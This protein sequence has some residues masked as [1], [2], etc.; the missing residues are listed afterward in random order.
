[1]SYA[2][3]STIYLNWKPP[4]SLDLSAVDRD[5][6]YCVDVY[7]ADATSFHIL[8]N[9]SVFDPHYNFSL[10]NPDPNEVFTFVVMPRSNVDGAPNGIPTTINASFSYNSKLT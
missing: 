3:S 10:D 7:K 5:I 9:C 2:T 1:M 8:R 4:F 6:I